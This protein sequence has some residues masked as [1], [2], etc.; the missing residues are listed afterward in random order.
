MRGRGKLQL[1][2]NLVELPHASPIAETAGICGA[3]LRARPV[4][5][6][7]SSQSAATAA[8]ASGTPL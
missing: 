1:S 5:A 8:P 7:K 4:P 2:G 6:G 3:R